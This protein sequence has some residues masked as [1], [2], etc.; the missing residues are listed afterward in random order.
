MRIGIAKLFVLR[1]A[2]LSAPCRPLR[3]STIARGAGGGQHEAPAA[4]AAVDIPQLAKMAQMDVTEQEVWRE[5]SSTSHILA[6]A[7][8]CVRTAPR[9]PAPCRACRQLIGNQRCPVLLIGALK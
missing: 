8:P 1:S 7:A 4:P 3:S 9:Q 6:A 5:I 2:P